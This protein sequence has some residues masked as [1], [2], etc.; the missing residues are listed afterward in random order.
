MFKVHMSVQWV[1]REVLRYLV[2]TSLAH[3]LES[4]AR[5]QI[6]VTHGTAGPPGIP[7]R[8]AVEQQT[9]LPDSQPDLLKF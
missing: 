3:T 1:L 8:C 7:P 2:G 5:D 9:Q 6:R 4:A